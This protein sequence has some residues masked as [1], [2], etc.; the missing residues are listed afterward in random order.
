MKNN[1]IGNIVELGDLLSQ[2]TEEQYCKKISVLSCSTIGQHVRHILEFY[3]CLLFAGKASRHVN[4]DDRPRDL[5][6]ESNI[7]FAKNVMKE[8]IDELQKIQEDF[9]ISYLSNY[10]YDEKEKSKIIPSSFY[11]ELAYNF[12]HSIHHQALIKVATREMK[13]SLLVKETFGYAPSTIRN[14]QACA[15]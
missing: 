15:Q 12:E 7:V 14:Q 10:S 3:Q 4:Y 2:L 8:V 1:I 5:R 6:I 9:P 11:R 13:L